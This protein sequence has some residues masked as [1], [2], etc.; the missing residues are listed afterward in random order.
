M[1]LKRKSGLNFKLWL[2]LAPFLGN[3]I[4][5]YVSSNLKRLSGI[6]VLDNLK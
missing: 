1:L 2:V 3:Y 6:I 4:N 5:T